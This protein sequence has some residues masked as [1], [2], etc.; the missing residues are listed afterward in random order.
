M[1]V[2]TPLLRSDNR[3][4]AQRASAS[5]ADSRAQHFWDLW[6]YANRTYAQQLD[7]PVQ[8]SWDLFVL[9]KPQV[10]WNPGLLPEPTMWMQNRN[11][12]K[13]IPYSQ[14]KLEAELQKWAP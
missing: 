8:E 10:H 3:S 1:V 7:L 6:S 14:D 12:D 4:A 9:Y 2:W 13:G 5:L 11:L